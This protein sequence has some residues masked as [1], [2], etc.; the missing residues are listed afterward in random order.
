MLSFIESIAKATLDLPPKRSLIIFPTQ[1]ACQEYKKEFAKQKNGVSWLPHVLPIRD[2]LSKLKTPFIADDL[3]LLLKLYSIH[4]R[5]FGEEEFSSFMS[6]GQQIID[7]FSEIDRQLLNA[8]QLFEEI[9]DLRTL[10]ERFEPGAEEAE[11]IR[12]FWSEFIRT[13]HTPL[14]NSFLKYWKQLP[15]L[16]SEFRKELTQSNIAYEGLG[17]R[18]VAEN[19][20]NE[21]YFDAFD[22]V[23]FCGFYAL[24]KT[25]EKLMDGLKQQGK[26]HLFVDADE[27]YTQPKHHEAGM[28][29]RKGYFADATLPWHQNLLSIPKESYIVKGCNGSYAL[30][31]ELA[32]DIQELLIGKPEILKNNS[33][34]IVLADESLLF[35]L[36]QHCHRLG[37]SLNPSMGFPLNHHPAFKTLNAIKLYRKIKQEDVNDLVK[38]RQLEELY[39]EPLVKRFFKEDKELN[40][41]G[42][43]ST[44]SES[45]FFTKMLHENAPEISSDKEYIRSFLN[46][47]HFIK[48][49]W[50]FPLHEHLLS[51][52]ELVF[53]ILEPHE[54]ELSSENWWEL[55]LT[56]LGAAKIPFSVSE[57]IPVMG[58][59]ET[60]NLDFEHVYIAPLNEGALPSNSASKSLIPYSLRKAYHLPCKEEQDAVTAYHFY[61]LLQRAKH[62][63][64]YFT[65]NLNDM[66]AGE[67]SRYLFQ[68]QHELLEKYPP[69]KIAYQQQ[70]SEVSPPL[71]LPIVV[72]KT[73]AILNRLKEKIFVEFAD[74]E[75]FPGLSASALNSY[76]ACSF[77][78]YLD[79]LA[80]IRPEDDTEG[81]SAGHF[82]NVLHRAMEIAYQEKEQIDE[83]TISLLLDKV[84]AIVEQAVSDA[85]GKP[86][87][88]GHDFLMK[89]VLTALV[90]M[91]FEY[92]RAYAPI[93]I[94]GLEERL[95]LKLIIPGHGEV[96]IKGIIDRLDIYEKYLRVLDYKTGKDSVKKT[97]DFETIFEDTKLKLNVQLLFY[98]FLVRYAYKD[99]NMPIKAGI[100][101]LRAFEDGIDWLNQGDVISDTELNDFKEK[102]VSKIAEILNPDIPF[103][104]TKDLEK[105]TFCDYKGLCSRQY[106]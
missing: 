61:R 27:F 15:L 68:L 75:K 62:L 48:E 71:V 42:A 78:F 105:C 56:E 57:G 12:T 54:S 103:E 72:A 7:D 24:N 3:T 44:P 65:T 80:G 99:G 74:P 9:Y 29:F 35:S 70:E 28:F 11:Y 30:S 37:I 39:D 19:F 87:N 53:S 8:D 5:F 95:S 97:D 82:G 102:L 36:F 104:Q 100:F 47:F 60:R 51:N 26:L 52:I 4:V 81:L 83:T 45:G 50:I 63:N 33:L 41:Q 32:N 18:L 94:K 10:D 88:T 23:A 64:F 106:A 79:Q 13:P 31:L 91:I 25:E 55:L 86:A 21:T 46:H 96:W 22:H 2:L 77:R 90:K 58:F 38:F 92:D 59:L 20:K 89:R 98:A 16:Y 14:Q 34:V 85:Y 1:R 66:G 49:D 69:I 6:Y 76:N 84:D 43:E 67:R 93:Q 73:D 101:K 17:W 40:L